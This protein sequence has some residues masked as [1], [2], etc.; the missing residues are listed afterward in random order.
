[1]YGARDHA[2]NARADTHAVRVA[3]LP[4]LLTVP[5]PEPAATVGGRWTFVLGPTPDTIAR[6][7]VSDIQGRGLLAPMLLASD[8]TASGDA[9]RGAFLAE[10]AQRRLMAPTPVIV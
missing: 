2:A 3:A 10:L 9:E 8:E 4:G 5:A 7:L 1:M 6:A